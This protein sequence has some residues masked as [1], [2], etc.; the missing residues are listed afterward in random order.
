M[1][2]SVGAV[3]PAAVKD[4]RP[5]CTELHPVVLSKT[6]PH[7]T[8]TFWRNKRIYLAGCHCSSLLSVCRQ[9]KNQFGLACPPR[10]LHHFAVTIVLYLSQLPLQSYSYT[11]P[12]QIFLHW[13]PPVS[14]GTWIWGD[15]DLIRFKFW[16]QG[17]IFPWDSN[18][19]GNILVSSLFNLTPTIQRNTYLEKWLY[20]IYIYF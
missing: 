10:L 11:F 14:C 2:S 7:E 20:N 17:S 1:V 16:S 12:T 3:K 4:L 13:R 9:K 15:I 5:L 6:R 19:E 18:R 8:V